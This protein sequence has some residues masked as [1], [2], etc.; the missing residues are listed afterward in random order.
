M[1]SPNPI[2]AISQGRADLIAWRQSDDGNWY[3]GNAALV[4]MV[5]HFAPH[6][7]A[8]VHS[9]L[10]HF[11][12]QVGA[13]EGLV[14]RCSHDPNL[15]V[16]DRFDY[17][18]RRQERVR[19]D[20]SYHEWGKIIYGSGVMSVTGQAGRAVE[21]AVLMIL[22]AHHGEAGHTCPLAC[23]AG[24]IKA[25]QR[26]GHP[27]LQKALLPGLLNPHYDRRL[28]GAQFLT[29]VQG[30]SDVGANATQATLIGAETA[31]N[32]ALW[33]LTGEKWFCSV[34]DAPLYVLTARPDGAAAGTKGLGLFIVPHDLPQ[35]RD[36]AQSPMSHT[37]FDTP[38]EP[39]QLTI[40]RLKHKLGTRAMAS[41]EVDW[42][43]ARGWQLGP[44]DQGFHHVVD[45]VLNTSRL[46]N[47]MACCGMLW[48]SYREASGFARFR[49]AF[50]QPIGHFANT[51]AMVAQVF[52][53]ACAATAST[54]DLVAIDAAGSDP[55]AVRL[56]LNMNKYW[57]SV[58]TTQMIRNAMEVIGGNAAIEDFT[59]L[60][61]LYRDALVTESWEGAH[62]VLIAQCWR[63]MQR[64]SLHRP[65]LDLLSRRAGELPMSSL[66]SA[67]RQRLAVLEVDAAELVASRNSDD[68]RSARAFVENAMVAHQ[69]L[70]LAELSQRAPTAIDPAVPQQF[71]AVHPHRRAVA[72]TGWWPERALLGQ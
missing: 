19:F 40:R 47:A 62:N 9:H 67:L 58:R 52:A 64:L 63:D 23:T 72:E 60:G 25:I 14:H 29:E 12:R 50:G 66:Q 46:W 17:L 69:G 37:L 24:M 43:G 6:A 26:C 57:T 8:Q 68:A 32:P 65:W 44:L 5:E 61:R 35:G 13:S 51:N 7:G 21:Q 2:D 48:R 41:G 70:C 22:S 36:V 34:I 59:P 27:A 54:L 18:G 10:E 28:Y 49:R 30:G 38:R 20:A 4:A 45:I 15:P 71:L 42:Q 16:L 31:E 1:N 56:G 55:D 33:A 3:R 53:E 39:N 11:G